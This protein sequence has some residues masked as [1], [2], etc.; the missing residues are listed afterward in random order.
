MTIRP[1]DLNGMLQNTH[2]VSTIKNNEDQK[3]IVQQQ[4]I[5]V[6]VSQQTREAGSKVQQADESAREDFRYDEREGDGS[7]YQGQKNKKKKQNKKEN[8][9]GQVMVKNARKSFD[10]KI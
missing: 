8:S 2:E 1:V 4:N 9:D 6:L 3:P 10:I 5:G 7:G